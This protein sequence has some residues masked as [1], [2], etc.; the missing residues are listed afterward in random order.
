MK[1]ERSDGVL[2]STTKRSEAYAFPRIQDAF[3][4]AKRLIESGKYN[5]EVKKLSGLY[6]AE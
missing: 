6:F 4:F 5:A 1:T 2:V 3:T